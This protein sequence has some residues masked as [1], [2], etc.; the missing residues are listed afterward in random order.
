MKIFGK[1]NTSIWLQSINWKLIKCFDSGFPVVTIDCMKRELTIF[2]TACLALSLNLSVATAAI[3]LG[4]ACKKVGQISTSAGIKYTCIKSGKKFIWNKDVATTVSKPK[5]SSSPTPTP[6][7]QSVFVPPTTPTSFS[8]L[9]KNY[10]GISWAVWSDVRKRMSNSNIKTDF[11]VEIGP[12]TKQ[13]TDK[14]DIQSLLKRAT[15]IYSDYAQPLQ[16]KVFYFNSADVAWAQAQHRSLTQPRFKESDLANNCKSESNCGAFG[17]ASMGVG[18]MFMG[19]HLLMLDPIEIYGGTEVHEFTHVVQYSLYSSTI[20]NNPNNF[21]PG[22]FT[23]GQA[24]AVQLASGTKDYEDYLKARQKWFKHAPGALTDYSTSEIL[25]FLDLQGVGK[26]D[27]ATWSHVYDIGCFV[28]ESLIAVGGLSST[29]ELIK[30]ISA[31]KDFEAAFESIYK[32]T[33]NEAR[34]AIADAVAAE[35]VDSQK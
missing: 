15:T 26:N 5:S 19:V 28:T 35:Y 20:F 10:K 25:R 24:S 21:L 3:K 1:R 13:P 11:I 30:E 8:D 18:A 29:L 2:A 4:S 33:W 7:A 22:W 27:S 17:S 14:P 31:G 32:I 6:I 12:T 23:E 16:T 34:A 9:V